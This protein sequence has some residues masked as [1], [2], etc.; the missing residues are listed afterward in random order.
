MYVVPVAQV[1]EKSRC[2]SLP[3]RE[4]IVTLGMQ[5]KKDCQEKLFAHFQL[6]ARIPKNNFY[7]CLKGAIDLDFLY[8]LT[9][10]Y[11]G[12]SGQKSI[13]PLVFCKL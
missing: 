8:P 2:R 5:G 9:K 6:S 13:D 12:D 11:Y 4:S 10:G 3:I 7:R 1:S